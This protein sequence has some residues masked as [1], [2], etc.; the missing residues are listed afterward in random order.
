MKL[1]YK[2][3]LQYKED[4]KSFKSF[5][6]TSIAFFMVYLILFFGLFFFIKKQSFEVALTV[7]LFG[8]LIYLL[9]DLPF[10]I[11]TI[12]VKRNMNSISRCISNAYVFQ[13]CLNNPAAHWFFQSKFSV[14]FEYNGEIKNFNT[15]WIYDSNNL[16]N[17]LVEVGYIKELDKIIIIKKVD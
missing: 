17:S 10:I 15:S 2:D 4:D 5:L 11:K 1:N 12:M 9:F 7:S 13:I 14:S 16:E 8:I 6:F 3:T